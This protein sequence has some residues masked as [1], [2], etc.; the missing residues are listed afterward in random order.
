MATVTLKVEGPTHV[1]QLY[2]II[3]VR[4]LHNR[5]MGLSSQSTINSPG[6]IH[7]GYT[8]P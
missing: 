5:H 2:L 3:V 6:F 1:P 4:A 7:E 8:P